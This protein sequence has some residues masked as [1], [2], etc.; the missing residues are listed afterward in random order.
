VGALAE[1]LRSKLRHLEA[2]GAAGGFVEGARS[3]ERVLLTENMEKHRVARQR[4][5]VLRVEVAEAVS[6]SERR[7]TLEKRAAEA[8]CHEE[9][10]AAVMYAQKTI[11][12]LWKEPS[13]S[14]LA[15]QAELRSV[16]EQLGRLK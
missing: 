6:G 15:T 2:A 11:K 7:A 16:T 1:T 5:E 10:V 12:R 13:A 3:T 9:T 8:R 14:Y 4:C